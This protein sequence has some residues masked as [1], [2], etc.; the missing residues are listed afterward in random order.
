MEEDNRVVIE[1]RSFISHFTG[2]IS[3]ILPAIE[4]LDRSLN[5]ISPV[6]ITTLGI[7][8]LYYSALSYGL[9]VIG[10]IGGRHG[11]ARVVSSSNT[12]PILMVVGIPMI[13]VVFICLEAANIEDK[14]LLLWRQK[15]SPTL[16][17]IP[18]FGRVITYFWPPMTR[19]PFSR[20]R[21]TDNGMIGVMDY[22]ARSITGG[23]LLPFMGYLLGKFLLKTK[24]NVFQR[25]LVVSYS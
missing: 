24:G 17:K 25:T 7:L 20:Y 3:N 1:R 6:G 22:L 13:P 12:H 8:T 5:S 19:E 21:P 4:R 18:L 16:P 23:L 14:T 9:V 2:R 10:M 15:V 11:L